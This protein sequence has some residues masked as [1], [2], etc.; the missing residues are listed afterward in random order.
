MGPTG[1]GMRAGSPDMFEGCTLAL[2]RIT[3]T[4]L[5]VVVV[6]LLS[7]TAFAETLCF[8]LGDTKGYV[9]FKLEVKPNCNVT[10]KQSTKISSVHG[11]GRGYE[12]G[13]GETESFLIVGTCEARPEFVNLAAMTMGAGDIEL[14][15]FGQSLQTGDATLYF[16]TSS[17]KWEGPVVPVKCSSLGL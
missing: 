4:V 2:M 3:S 8:T 16:G 9:D 6:F 1:P 17:T 14:Y 11:T 12:T 7:S 10:G 13:G 15:I 5:S